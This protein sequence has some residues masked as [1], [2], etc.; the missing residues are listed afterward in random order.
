MS[1]A[2]MSGL[3]HGGRVGIYTAT[4]FAVVGLMEALRAELREYGI[5]TS[6]LCPGLVASEIYD[7]DRNR[8]AR[9]RAIPTKRDREL[10]KVYRAFMTAG[11]DPLECGRK[12]L[13]GV[14]RNDLYILPHPEF[15]KGLRDRWDVLRSSIR[16]ERD[17][18]PAAR[19]AA[20]NK[21]LRHD[22]YIE[23]KRRL[24]ARSSSR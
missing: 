4:K 14:R 3:F 6:V 11:M 20:E 21:T 19:L 8:P 22:I 17:A 15:E 1:T 10:A 18:V 13:R 16:A 2:S 24:R 23:E 7:S 9:W 12:A 5:G